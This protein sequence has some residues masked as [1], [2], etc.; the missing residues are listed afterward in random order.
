MRIGKNHGNID[1]HKDA[2]IG[3]HVTLDSSR[4]EKMIIG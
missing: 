1:I 4:G 3:K 2:K